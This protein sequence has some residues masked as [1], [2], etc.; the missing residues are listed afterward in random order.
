MATRQPMKEM[1]GLRILLDAIGAFRHID[2]MSQLNADNYRASVLAQNPEYHTHT[3]H[4][5]FQYHYIW[6]QVTAKKVHLQYCASSDM[7]ANILTRALERVA[8]H[9][10]REAMSIVECNKYGILREGTC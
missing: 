6:D 3:K 8:H 2:P 4:I 1:I 7:V 10:H 9:K 5:D